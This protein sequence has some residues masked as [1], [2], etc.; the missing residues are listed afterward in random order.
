MQLGLGAVT[1]LGQPG[2]DRRSIGDQDL[3]RAIESGGEQGGAL[4]VEPFQRHR[5][6]GICCGQSQ[7]CTAADVVDHIEGEDLA[8]RVQQLLQSGDVLDREGLDSLLL[9]L[10]DRRRHRL[11]EQRCR[12]VTADGVTEGQV[13]EH[14]ER[15]G[16]V[17]SAEGVVRRIL[18]QVQR[19]ER[20]VHQAVALDGFEIVAQGLTGLAFD[21]A[22]VGDHPG[23]VAVLEDP[24][25]GRLRAD[26]R[27]A[28]EVVR[29]LTDQRREVRVALRGDAVL[30]LHGRRGHPTHLGDA[31]DG[32]QQG[33]LLTDQLDRIAV[34]RDD[35]RLVARGL[36]ARG[37]GGD[38]VVGLVVLIGEP[39]HPQGIQHLLDQTD[40]AMEGRRG[41]VAT[42]F[43]LVV[44][45][46]TEG[47]AGQVEG[48]REVRRPL[49][50]DHVDD[51]AGEAVHGIGGLSSAI[52][53]ALRR[54]GEEGAERH[55]MPVDEEDPLVVGVTRSHGEQS[56]M[57]RR[58]LPPRRVVA[59]SCHDRQH[60]P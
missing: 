16:A 11:A 48:D 13:V 46:V 29:R 18:G 43:V 28:G 36:G 1:V 30:L 21:L 37:E 39:A 56:P 49:G 14:L 7:Q 35:Q 26:A 3:R 54:Q 8:A 24:L 20:G 23:Q 15:A 60:S 52:A 27:D 10:G 5:T 17:T 50:G 25:R 2:T 44:D 33:D 22:G 9:L 31:L 59:R 40:L 57:S 58:H 32:L 4:R 6:A 55:R 34:A 51:H 12:Q 19:G 41:L 42:A 45:A 53:E 47:A 38:D